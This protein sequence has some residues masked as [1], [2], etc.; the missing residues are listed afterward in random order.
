MSLQLCRPPRPRSARRTVSPPPIDT[1][2]FGPRPGDALGH[3]TALA[4]HLH[5]RRHAVVQA[6]EVRRVTRDDSTGFSAP[7]RRRSP[8]RVPAPRSVDG[9]EEVRRP[10]TTNSGLRYLISSRTARSIASGRQRRCAG[11]TAV[12]EAVLGSGQ[13]RSRTR[14]A[15]TEMLGYRTLVMRSPFRCPAVCERLSGACHLPL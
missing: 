9:V 3:P 7:G 5:E 12:T 6:D 14:R 8:S 1:T 13:A 10:M 2:F 15:T 11:L 4:L